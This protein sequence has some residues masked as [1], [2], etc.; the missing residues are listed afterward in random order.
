MPGSHRGRGDNFP[1]NDW[2]TLYRPIS[3]TQSGLCRPL[4]V[5][6]HPC[7][8]DKYPPVALKDVETILVAIAKIKDFRT[9]SVSGADGA[10]GYRA[11]V[12][13]DQTDV[14]DNS[15]EKCFV[16]VIIVEFYGERRAGLAV[17]KLRIPSTSS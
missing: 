8:Y 14:K 2:S 11:C 10:C 12:V 6:V 5:T 3:S 1:I 7:K 9:C 13:W 15:F 17:G 16:L 4:P